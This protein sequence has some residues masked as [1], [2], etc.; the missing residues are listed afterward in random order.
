MKF[1]LALAI[2]ALAFAGY[3]LTYSRALDLYADEGTMLAV[4]DD[5]VKFGRVSIDQTNHLQYIHHAAIG[6]DAARYSKYGIGQS[7]AAAPLYAFGLWVPVF[8]L[9]DVALLLNPLAGALSVTLVF[10][11]ALELGAARRHALI[12]ALVVAFATPLWVYSKNFFSE[13]LSAL[14]LTLAT[15]GVARMTRRRSV[16]GAL[17]A[18]G[19]LALAMLVKLSM[20]IVAPVLFLVILGLGAR[21]VR[22]ALAA[23]YPLV[24]AAL[25][26]GA[27]NFARFGDALHSGY[28]DEAFTAAPWLGVLGMLFAPGRG[29]FIFAP[30]LFAAIPGWLKLRAPGLR[31][32]VIGSALAILA[33]HGAWWS[34]WGGWA[35]GPRFLVPLMPL[36]GLGILPWLEN[37]AT[38]TRGARWFVGGVVALSGVMQLAGALVSRVFFFWEVMRQ[39]PDLNPDEVA[40]YDVRV[41]MP[42]FNFEQ[43]LRGNLDLAWKPGVAAPFDGVGLA[44]AAIALGVGVAGVIAATRGVRWAGAFSAL[45]VASL[46]LIAL[47]RYQAQD[48]NPFAA[49]AFQITT[50]VPR[51]AVLF[52]GDN[53]APTNQLWW[54]ANRSA[55]RIVGVPPHDLGQLQL[56]ALPVVRRELSV[57]QAIWYLQTEATLLPAFEHE[58]QELNLCE[59]SQPL[60]TSVRLVRWTPC[61]QQTVNS[62]PDAHDPNACADCQH[63]WN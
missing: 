41:F 12:A 35:W 34:W 50:Q 3:W 63:D 29:A 59:S 33:V 44:L 51:D 26:I 4:T 19:G 48:A 18:G 62:A 57:R 5:L 54:N 37:P 47:A 61:E 45:G 31:L 22:F 56:H 20:G 52:V 1:S 7:L 24:F 25:A 46:V 9:V 13:P 38:Q 60:G 28:G 49:V 16:A 10:L 27:Y 14:G 53:A 36:V 32:W 42:L 17:I 40:L 15:W 8:G 39:F 55:L 2:F 58:L 11:I 43:A 21:R 30:V 23:L 6:A